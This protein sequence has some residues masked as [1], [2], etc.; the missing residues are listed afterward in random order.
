MPAGGPRALAA[1]GL[2]LT[3]ATCRDA[4]GPRS[5]ILGRVAVAP[6]FPSEEALREF[7]LTID[8]VRFIVVRPPADTI[9]DTTLALPAEATELALDLRV[10]L[11]AASETLSVSVVALGGTIPLFAGTS[12]VPVPSRLPPTVIPV[13]TYVG[14]V[15]DSIAIQPRSPFILVNDALRFQVQG[16][17]NGGTPVT[18]FYVAWSTSDAGVA[19]INTFGVLRAPASRGSVRVLARTPCGASD[20]VTATFTL[21]ATQL[22]PVAGGGQVDTVGDTLVTPLEVRALAVDGI[23]VGGISV[24]FRP[25]VGGGT[26]VDT[27]VVTDSAGRA[28][29]TARLGGAIGIQTFEASAAGLSGSPVTFGATALAGPVAQVLAAAGD[30]QLA[31]VNTVVATAPRV[32]V[33]DGGGNP[34]A[35]VTVTFAVTTGGGSVTGGIDTTDASGLATVGSWTLDTLAGTNTLRATVAGLTR[36]FTATGVAGTAA[37]LVATAGDLQSAVVGNAVA[38]DPA[39]RAEDQFGNP[40]AGTSI[41]FAVSGG[42][43]SVSGRAQL[44]NAAG[45]AT[46]GG[47]TLDTIAATNAL[48]A[49]TGTLSLGFTATGVPEAP[50]R[51][52]KVLGDSQTAVVNTVVP[53][54]PTV[55][56]SDRYGNPIAGD[57][58]DFSLFTDGGFVASPTSVTD[59]GGLASAGAWTLANFVTQ[60]TLQASVRGVPSLLPIGFTAT[61][62]PDAPAQLLR[63]SVDTQTTIAGQAVSVPPAVQVVDQFFNPVPGFT[64]TF[65][66]AGA[67][68]GSLT[69]DSAATDSSGVARVTTWTLATIA[70]PNTLDAAAPGLVGSPITFSANGITTTATNMALDAGD[71]QSGI[72]A[73]LL[74]TAYSVVVRDSAGLPVPNVQVHW[75]VDP[76][77]GSMSP[78]TSPTDVNGIAASTRTLGVAAGTQTATASIGGLAGSPVIF[79]ATALAGAP[80]RLVKQSVDLQTSTVATAVTA[81]VVKVTDQFGNGVAAVIVDFAVTAGGGILGAT[82]DTS[83][84]LGLTTAGAWTL[85]SV[86]GTNG[87]TATSGLLPAVGFTATGVAGAPAR[88]AFLTEPTHALAGDTIDS[89]VQVV[90]QDQ[91]GNTVFPATDVVT[92]GLGA[93]PDPAAKLLGTVDAAASRGVAVFSNLAIDSAE[94]GYTLVATAGNLAGAE[95]N[96]FDVG[97]VIAAFTGERLDPVAAAFNPVNGLV[98]VPGVENTLGVLDPS[99][100]QLSVLPILQ[101]QPF[102]VAVN[103]TT[104]RVYVTTSMLLVGA[105]VV[106]D[107]GD[108]A[109]IATIPLEGEARGIAI[110]E[111]TDRIFVAVAGDSVKL[112]PPT[113]AV[114]DGKDNGVLINIPFKDGALEGVGVAF[115]PNDR[116]VYVAIPNLGVGIFDPEAGVHV[117]TV[118][119]V[120][121][122]GAAGTYGVAVDVRSNLIYA[123]NR[124]EGTVSLV[125]PTKLEEISRLP[126]GPQPEGLGVDA[127]RG[128]VYVGNSGDNTVSLIDGGK[129]SVFA[130]LIVGPT[131][132]AAAVDAATGRVYVPT[133]GDD[134]VRVILP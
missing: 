122:K 38:I 29:T 48:T 103:A 117:T 44:T 99:K 95:S 97:G 113:L 105:V 64:V 89:P 86:A 96:R 111:A 108:N 65:S 127:E 11:V 14:P 133:F 28:R 15:A 102:G 59:T 49:T 61:G 134:R 46:V 109:P 26:V 40:V 60:N 73:T 42:G 63:V 58:V 21:P 56:L 70:G 130:T 2:A 17:K 67:L 118:P 18:Q 88:L 53:V 90:V 45:V 116:L 93:L 52:V 68:I 20:S 129:F 76:A 77:G 34:V 41:T 50:S 94:I 32:Q 5:T 47:W 110:D 71:G 106:I 6:V 12:L 16:F 75:A 66:L 123:T 92:M 3:V 7:G 69:P 83:D 54:T 1:L 126:V 87:V 79:T 84:G 33:K 85:G 22:V 25:L 9:A 112:T 23:G 125:D 36:T 128:V 43:G 4:L 37:R 72:V 124:T 132:K 8:A 119:I 39:V 114:I 115:N 101:S 107:A 13:D 24:R 91:F 51:L 31:T 27:L 62:I 30:G 35:G 81:P 10:P 131:P 74:P 100:E 55:R 80:A 19:T 121:E 78:S 82:K 57:T 98:Y 104:N 120:S